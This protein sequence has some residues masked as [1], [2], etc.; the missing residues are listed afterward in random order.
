MIG[1]AAVLFVCLGHLALAAKMTPRPG[2][3]ACR[4]AV[5]GLM[6][7]L[8]AGSDNTPLYRDTYN[9]VVKTCGPASAPPLAAEPKGREHCHELAAAL[10]DL[11]EDGK[12]ASGAFVKAR[13][14]FATACGPR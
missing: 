1:A 10:V 12:M 8:D 2:A 14:D 9:V 11:I 3:G 4:E 6:S 5:N 13:G 7:L